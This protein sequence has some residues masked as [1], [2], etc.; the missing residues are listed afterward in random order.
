MDSGADG[1]GMP[2][3]RLLAYVAALVSVTTYPG[4]TDA[5]CQ[6]R[7]S[8]VVIRNAIADVNSLPL[9]RDVQSSIGGRNLRARGLGPAAF[10][11]RNFPVATTGERGVQASRRR[12][13]ARRQAP[14]LLLR[15]GVDRG[16]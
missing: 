1:S 13:S 2:R 4:L 11:D 14:A 10:R 7:S 5:G 9:S 6:S 16:L 15:G 3:H 12:T 8:P